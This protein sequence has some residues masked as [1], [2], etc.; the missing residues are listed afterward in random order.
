MPNGKTDSM[1]HAEKTIWV[2]DD[3]TA[4]LE[5]MESV[6]H[7]EEYNV[8]VIN[9]PSTVERMLENE[10]L[11]DLIYLD[12]LMPVIDGS[13]IARLLKSS[14]WTK[15]IPLVMLSANISGEQISHEAK[16]DGFLKKPFDIGTLIEVT[17]KYLSS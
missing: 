8:V 10:K 17:K 3:D 9:D 12:I 6:L 7:D 16:A 1:K 15:H 11:P 4:I 2:I 13:E 14:D 5:A